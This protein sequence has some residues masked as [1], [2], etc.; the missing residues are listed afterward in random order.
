MPEPAADDAKQHNPWVVLASTSL[1][2]FAVFLDTTILFVA[3]PSIREQFSSTEPST[4]SWILNAYTIVFAALLI[5]A[6]RLADRVGRR[7]TFLWAAVVF[8]IASMLCGLAP[9][10]GVLIVARILQAVAA[11]A[12]VPASLALVLQTFP[13]HKIPVAVAIWGAVGAV[14]GAA[15]PTLGALVIENLGWRWAFYINLPVGIVSFLL[16]RRVLPEWRESNPGRLP[17]PTG[18]VV[19]ASGLALAAYGIVKTDQ[20]G[21][22]SA[23]FVAAEL[24]AAVLIAWFVRRCSKVANPVLDLTLFESQS[25][26]WANAAMLIYATGFSAMFLGNV[27]FLTGVWHYSILRAGMAIS[28]GPLIVAATAPLFG[29]LAGRVGQRRLLI[30]GG[31]IWALS[32]VLLINRVTVHPD[33]VSH[34]LPSVILSGLGVALCLP[35]LSSAAVQGLP[36]HRFG[37]G[38]AVSQAVR[39]LGATLGVAVAVA[40]TAELTP[41][42]AIDSFH[43]VWWLLVGS[44]VAVSILTTRL[45]RRGARPAVPADV[46]PVIAEGALT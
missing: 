33:Y 35:Q 26:R 9:T 24:V 17:D 28:V 6:G 21:W 10:V 16:G 20:W 25:F 37:S 40:F 42:T 31:L 30:P 3:F 15:G 43:H 22:G 1:A 2:V 34:Y 11:A 39:N 44:G 41:A 27:L 46:A 4:L 29:K 12:L 19:L 23:K 7:K 8:T 5:P 38:S 14:A 32:G 45:P 13:R 18:V 36:T